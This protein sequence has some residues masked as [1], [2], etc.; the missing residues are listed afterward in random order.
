MTS[1]DFYFLFKNVAFLLIRVSTYWLITISLKV[2]FGGQ[3]GLLYC[4]IK[5]GVILHYIKVFF[6]GGGLILKKGD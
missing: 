1:W 2:S 3:G 4:K 5:R 6:L